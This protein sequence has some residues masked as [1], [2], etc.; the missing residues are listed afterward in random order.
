MPGIYAAIIALLGWYYRVFSTVDILWYWRQLVKLSSAMSVFAQSSWVLTVLTVSLLKHYLT[1]TSVLWCQRG[2]VYIGLYHIY[3]IFLLL[4][5]EKNNCDCGFS[6]CPERL[7]VDIQVKYCPSE[8]K[9]VVWRYRTTKST[10]EG[11]QGKWM[12][13]NKISDFLF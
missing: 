11:G 6:K 4:R 5:P 13:V 3:Y 12:W 8:E 9:E 2:R 7:H 10:E 1:G